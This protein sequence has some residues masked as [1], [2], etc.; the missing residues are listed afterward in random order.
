MISLTGKFLIV[1]G[2]ILIAT[3]VLLIYFDKIP[4]IGKLPGD[5]DIK[6]GN[7]QFIFPFTTSIIIS[8]ILSLIFWVFSYLNRK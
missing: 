4:F 7:F 2:F 1:F 8:V 6:K 5:S 3:G